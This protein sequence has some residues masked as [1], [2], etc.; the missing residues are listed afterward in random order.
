MQISTKIETIRPCVTPKLFTCT[1]A[2]LIQVKYTYLPFL[3][4]HI[5]VCW[6]TSEL[7]SIYPKLI[8]SSSLQAFLLFLPLTSN[9]S[10]KSINCFNFSFPLRMP[11]IFTH[12]PVINLCGSFQTFLVLIPTRFLIKTTVHAT[13]L[14]V[15]L[16]VPKS[17]LPL[18]P[19]SIF[20][21]SNHELGLGSSNRG[22]CLYRGTKTRRCLC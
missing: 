13:I 10:P 1:T 7:F 14:P 6:D 16:P 5:L 18:A 21:T 8:L 20:F 2:A 19:F 15:A 12:Y 3:P 4:W 11:F 17:T 9:M 22:K